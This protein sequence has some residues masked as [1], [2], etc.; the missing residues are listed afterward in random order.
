MAQRDQST[1]FRDPGAKK[2][3]HLANERDA[4]R[5][6]GPDRMPTPEEEEAA[7]RAKM[8]AGTAKAY[9]EA[10]ERGAHQKGEGRIE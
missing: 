3:A 2:E 7:E 9:E 10:L 5:A 1:D 4:H 8:P 6:A